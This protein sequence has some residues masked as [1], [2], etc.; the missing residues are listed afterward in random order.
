MK[1]SLLDRIIS[2]DKLLGVTAIAIAL[3]AAFF[4][5]YGIATLFAGAFVLTAIMASTLEIGKLVAVTYLYRYWNKTQSFLKIYLS[6]ATFVLMLITSLGIF[7]YLSSAYQKSSMEY[8]ANQEKIVMVESQKTYMSDKITQSKIRIQTLNDMRRLQE[9]RMN[10]T[11]T[12]AF[13]T[14]NP[15]QLKQLQ[16]QTVEIIKSA[17]KDIKTEQDKIQTTIDDI[18]KVDQQV[19][20]MKFSSAN[21]KDIR[22]FQ[23]VADQFGVTL[24]EVAK[25]FMFTIIF[26]F[27]P[28]AVALILAYNVVIYKKKNDEEEIE[29]SI[30]PMSLRKEEKELIDLPIVNIPESKKEVIIDTATTTTTPTIPQTNSDINNPVQNRQPWM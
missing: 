13:L 24:D 29:D 3:V 27:D 20:E 14:R 2:F 10:E 12:N 1:N 22:T 23:F 28:L 4:S 15:I 26:V 25:W 19:N 16:E 30:N 18:S 8:K 17:D 9:G 21:K 5:V 7:G 6:I 11:L